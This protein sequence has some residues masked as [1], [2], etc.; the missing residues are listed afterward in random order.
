[1]RSKAAILPPVFLVASLL[2]FL[3]WR[4][5]N[6]PN[7]NPPPS[8]REYSKNLSDLGSQPDWS[9]LDPSQGAILQKDFLTELDQVF[10]V[11]NTWKDHIHI[12]EDAAFIKTNDPNKE[13]YYR[14]AFAKEQEEL[15]H[16]ARFWK[17]AKELNPLKEGSPLDGIHIALDPGHIGGDFAKIEERWFQIGDGTPV[18][19]GEM[20]LR[21][22]K[23]LKKR[24]QKLGAKVTIVRPTNAPINK[25]SPEDFLS[26]AKER[27]QKISDAQR[28]AERLFY[29]TAEIRERARRVNE[30]I[31]PDLVI[32]LHFNAVAW[33]DPANPT[34]RDDNHLHILL[35]GALTKNEIAHADERFDMIQKI[36]QRIHPE[37]KAIASSIS[38]SFVDASS[39][40]AYQYEANSKRAINIDNNPYLWSRNLLANR[41]YRCPVIYMEPYVM[42]SHAVYTRIQH[43]DYEGLQVIDGLPRKSIFR[44]Y[45]DAVADGIL[46]HYRENRPQLNKETHNE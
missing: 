14:L 3:I 34:L 43:G 29:R 39:L 37:E 45:A 1:M 33:G 12:T 10:T 6:S 21:T 19:E 24:L 4:K 5:Q 36:V 30:E 9:E 7:T 32:C 16:P 18:M 17:T 15:I 31:K 40:P 13:L 41:L 20:T 22:A 25:N 27:S 42:N 46:N 38:K 2:A 44:E 35:H 28:I 26:M 8:N 23:L 11:G